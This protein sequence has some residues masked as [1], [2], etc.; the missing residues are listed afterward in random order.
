MAFLNKYAK[1]ALQHGPSIR[2]GSQTATTAVQDMG[3]T[4][5]FE[6]AKGFVG[7]TP[8]SKDD[9]YRQL[10]EKAKVDPEQI[11]IVF[12]TGAPR[13]ALHYGYVSGKARADSKEYKF[14]FYY[15]KDG[16]IDEPLSTFEDTGK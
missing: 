9:L 10:A 6:D 13:N 3:D 1:E 2:K 16:S 11:D 8:V 5:P 14:A 4:S 12:L 15:N 7:K